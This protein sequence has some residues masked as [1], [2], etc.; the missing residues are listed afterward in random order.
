MDDVYNSLKVTSIDGQQCVEFSGLSQSMSLTRF[1]S[2]V[3][4]R[5]QKLERR[6]VNP[7]DLELMAFGEIMTEG[8]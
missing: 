3:A 8:G 5:I 1:K 2:L 4:I 7:A 6:Y